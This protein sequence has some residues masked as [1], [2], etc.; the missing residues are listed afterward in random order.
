MICMSCSA[1]V[2]GGRGG[3][4]CQNDFVQ[5]SY[6]DGVPN[7]M[8]EDGPGWN[9]WLFPR[10]QHEDLKWSRPDTWRKIND[11]DT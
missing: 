4:R 11:T 5:G 6:P 9:Y 7:C 10:D 3:D 1:R 8:K 2:N